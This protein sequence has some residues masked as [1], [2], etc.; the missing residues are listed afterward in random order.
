MKFK[1]A[2]NHDELETFCPP[3]K[4]RKKNIKVY[5]W[6][7]DEIADS[8][9][10]KPVYFKNPKR[11]FNKEEV[12]KCM[13]MSLSMWDSLEN[14]RKRSNFLKINMG[15]KFYKNIGTKV[16]C[17]N[18][19]PNHGVNSKIDKKGHFSHHPAEG[20]IYSDFFEII[21]DL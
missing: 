4:F 19:T 20:V 7:F 1:Y 21:E 9:N 11:F 5:H 8:E 18:L 13:A 17:G 14:S 3:K 10:F 2:L 12:K 15:E 6:I 16:A